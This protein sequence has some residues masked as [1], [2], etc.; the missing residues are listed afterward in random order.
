MRRA[1]LFSL[2]FAIAAAAFAA[3]G[4]LELYTLDFRPLEDVFEELRERARFE[5]WTDEE[6]E[7]SLDDWRTRFP[8]GVWDLNLW[9]PKDYHRDY[10]RMRVAVVKDGELVERPHFEGF[11]IRPDDPTGRLGRLSFTVHTSPPFDVYVVHDWVDGR[12]HYRFDG[13]RV[14]FVEHETR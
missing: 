9:G 6:L 3:D 13:E 7:E 2:M 4:E 10:E 8:A 14:E 12:Y 5:F 1:I 11:M